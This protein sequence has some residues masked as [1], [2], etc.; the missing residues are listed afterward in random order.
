[1]KWE[2][3]DAEAA[4]QMGWW[5]S[6]IHVP[7]NPYNAMRTQNTSTAIQAYGNKFKDDNSARDYV[8]RSFQCI[9]PELMTDED[10]ERSRICGKAI[11]LCLE[12]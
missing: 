4:K 8:L 12:G 1:M 3:K 7:K 10:Y 6:R 9:R 5:L 11:L 2:E